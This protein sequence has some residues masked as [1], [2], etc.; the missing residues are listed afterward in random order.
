[1]ENGTQTG[2]Y[3]AVYKSSVW[4]SPAKMSAFAVFLATQTLGNSLLSGIVWYERHGSD[5]YYRT[6]INQ[7]SERRVYQNSSKIH[8]TLCS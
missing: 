1:M 3:D 2:A 5:T 4:S 7:V 8:F 6:L